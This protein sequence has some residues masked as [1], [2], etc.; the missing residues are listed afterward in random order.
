[1][2]DIVLIRKRVFVPVIFL[3]LLLIVMT[4]A[5]PPNISLQ[6]NMTPSYKNTYLPQLEVGANITSIERK[7]RPGEYGGYITINDT[8]VV[9]NNAS[10][11]LYGIYYY[12]PFNLTHNLRY[13]AA[14]TSDN[15]PLTMKLVKE[16][17]NNMTKYVVLFNKPLNPYHNFSFVVTT[18]YVGLINVYKSDQGQTFNFTL[19]KFPLIDITTIYVKVNVLIPFSAVLLNYTSAFDESAGA[20]VNESYNLSPFTYEHFFVNYT[21]GVQPAI[22]F[23]E[24]QKNYTV[25]TQVGYI[26]V[27]EK[28]TI[29]NVGYSQMNSYSLYIPGDAYDLR[30]RDVVGNV[31]INRVYGDENS[32]TK[33]VSYIFTVDLRENHSYTYWIYYKLPVDNYQKEDNLD[34]ILTIDSYSGITTVVRNLTI[35]V[36]LPIGS[37]ILNVK[38]YNYTTYAYRDFT[39]IQIKEYN[40]TEYNHVY[41]NIR[42][43]PSITGILLRGF[44]YSLFIAIVTS[45]YVIVRKSKRLRIVTRAPAIEEKVIPVEELKEFTR[46]YDEKMGYILELEHL[47]ELREAG[48]ITKRDYELK[49]RKF[50]TELRRIEKELV[51]SSEALKQAGER[52]AK[53]VRELELLEE[54]R[55]SAIAN[56]KFIKHRYK[57][58][59]ISK[60]VYQKMLEEQT[61]KLQRATSQIDRILFDLKSL[62]SQ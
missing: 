40:I 1:M 55:A 37:Q 52:Y 22:E 35:N 4:I 59:R 6:T 7:V 27:V 51:P 36:M 12:V 5:T 34:L 33:R 21:F 44:Y 19:F 46:L 50:T 8:F 13:I 15:K 56:I 45:L 54:Q 26:S 14:F 60:A 11:V 2:E 47:D 32:P 61:K 49:K 41:I 17:V 18:A 31:T 43:V 10:H 39:V 28:H 42:Y 24:V 58:R 30:I 23:T 3:M 62:I 20:L 29:Q 48:K 16:N 57:L 9:Y 25:L 53:A 38:Y